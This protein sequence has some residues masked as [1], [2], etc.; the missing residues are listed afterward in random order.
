MQ[1]GN[2]EVLKV[3]H[4]AEF[5]TI[6][7]LPIYD[8]VVIIVFLELLGVKAVPVFQYKHFLYW[9][10]DNW[11]QLSVRCLLGGVT[12]W[13]CINYNNPAT[14]TQMWILTWK[15]IYCLEY[16]TTFCVDLYHL[17]GFHNH[18]DNFFRIFIWSSFCD[19]KSEDTEIRPMGN[20]IW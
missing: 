4:L 17:Y 7:F 3:A 16:L 20:N 8:A 14:I 18:G 13:S 19:A 2:K 11:H 1:H 10:R 12:M 5:S 15:E 6:K 9:K